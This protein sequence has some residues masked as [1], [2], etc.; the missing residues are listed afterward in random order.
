M[1]AL[2]LAVIDMAALGLLR[3]SR[4]PRE[5]LTRRRGHYAVQSGNCHRRRAIAATTAAGA[6]LRTTTAAAA[7][8]TATQTAEGTG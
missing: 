4:S 8:V 2:D 5:D 7:A 3:F 1:A 6:A